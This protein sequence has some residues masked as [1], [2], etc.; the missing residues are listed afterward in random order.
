MVGDKNDKVVAHN[1][2]AIKGYEDRLVIFAMKEDTSIDATL[3]GMRR[4]DPESHEVSIYESTDTENWEKV[5]TFPDNFRWIFEAP[6]ETADGHLLCIA[7]LKEGPAILR[8]PGTD[9]C[10]NP[11]IIPVLQE[12]GAVF[13]Y[14]ESTWYQTDDGTIVI[15]WRDEGMSCRVWVSF[16]SDG[17][18]TFSP[19]MISD[20]PDSMSRIY[21]GRLNDGRYYLCNNAFPTL[22]NRRHLMLMLSDDGYLFNKVY[23]VVDDPTS[24]RLAGLL[25]EDGYQYP[26]CLVDG[27]KL[28]IGYSVNKEDI[29]CGIIGTKEI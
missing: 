21:A 7:S 12:H 1:C 22:L 9:V 3:P 26:C 18:K 24:Q 11:E 20:M 16:S 17:G 13:P 2:I 14:G 5:F 8:W 10:E 4:V 28:L 15:F 19:P 29:E 6:R 25:K 23:I 27:D